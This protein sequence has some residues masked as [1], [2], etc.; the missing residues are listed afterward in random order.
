MAI[1][2]ACPGNI[3]FL[4]RCH[5]RGILTTRHT[6]RPEFFAGA[7]VLSHPFFFAGFARYLTPPCGRY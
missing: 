1:E 6:A 2:V 7:F 5:F 4:L 3:L